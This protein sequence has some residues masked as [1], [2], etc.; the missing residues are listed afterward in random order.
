MSDNLERFY[1]ADYFSAR[2]RFREAAAAADCNVETFPIDALGPDAQPLTIDVARV[3]RKDADKL[4]IVSSGLHGIEGFFGSAVQLAWLDQLRCSAGLPD[5]TAVLLLHALNPYGF[6]WLRRVNENNVDPNR[7]GLLPHEKFEG[8][9]PG[10][11]ELDGLL[12]P[13]RPPK[14]FEPFLPKAAWLIA[15]KGLSALKQ[16]VAAGQYDFPK[17][18]FYG[19][20]QLSQSHQIVKANLARWIAPA[21]CVLHV[22]FH[23]GLGKSGTFKLLAEYGLSE[24]EHT[25][26]S[27]YFDAS[28]IENAEAKG[29]AYRVRGGLGSWCRWLLNDVQYTY[30][31]AEF[32]TYSPIKV[33]AGLRAEN[34]AVH[35]GK[36]DAPQTKQAKTR[37]KE[38]FCP[39]SE[40]WRSQAL[41]SGVQ[42]IQ[43]A[44]K[45][46]TH[47]AS[48]R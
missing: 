19:G 3:G 37:L 40:T 15:R 33:I 25:W 5:S 38:L 32:G 1:S 23:T 42:L 20:D 10:Y 44:T 12:N 11:A 14:R 26:L 17:G 7:N 8:S 27:Q 46:V 36:P 4:V 13:T 31:C 24:Q 35:W 6:A 43:S 2:G 34:R 29:V 41:C 30:L 48:V 21:K 22:D 18:L 47:A 28:H 45:S 39:A 9:P 16:A